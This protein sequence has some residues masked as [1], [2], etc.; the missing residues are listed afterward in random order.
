M[1]NY[2]GS[3]LLTQFYGPLVETAYGVWPS[4]STGAHFY[5][6]KGGETLSSKKIPVQGEGLFYGALHA[7]ASRRVV[8]GWDAGGGLTLEAPTRNFQQW[9]Y[10]MFGSYGQAAAALTQDAATGA[11][12]AVHAPGP[13]ETNSFALQKGVT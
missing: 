6:I 2:P 13:L 3:G 7:Q 9:L 8:A 10:P 11:Y 5:A 4:P 12:K 1:S